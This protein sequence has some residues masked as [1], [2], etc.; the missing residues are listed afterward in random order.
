MEQVQIQNT[1]W[2]LFI[3]GAT[4][5][6]IILTVLFF[7]YGI[8]TQIFTSQTA[9]QTFLRQFGWFAPIIFIVFQAVQVVL[10]ICPGA[11]GCIGGILIFGPAQGFIYN[12]IGICIG[13][14]AAFLIARRYGIN[15]VKNMSNKK[16]FNKYVGWLKKSSFERLF[17]TA[18]FMPVAPDD[19]LCYIAG[20]SKITFKRFVIIILLG[21]PFAIAMYCFVLNFIIQR[22]ISFL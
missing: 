1:K 16:T 15:Y 21:K 2:K 17:A 19:F 9:L 6:G 8:K 10:P 12:Y 14:I 4:F 13:S 3:N 18:I 7:M 20:I 5:A 22:L 11:I